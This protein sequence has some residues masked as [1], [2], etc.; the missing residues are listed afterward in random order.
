MVRTKLYLRFCKLNCILKANILSLLF[1]SPLLIKARRVSCLVYL[2]MGSW[3]VIYQLSVWIVSLK[4]S[5]MIVTFIKKLIKSAFFF[6]QSKHP[7]E[8]RS[9]YKAECELSTEAKH[10]TANQTQEMVMMKLKRIYNNNV[11]FDRFSA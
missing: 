6:C 3:Q 7:R 8:R 2:P 10:Y 5:K 11:L 1:T 9:D 4:F